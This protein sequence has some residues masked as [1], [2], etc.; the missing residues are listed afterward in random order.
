MKKITAYVWASGLIEFGDKVPDGALPV[1]SGE[2]KAVKDVIEVLA[3]HSRTA[4]VQLLVPGIPEAPNQRLA[5]EAL[6][7]FCRDV[8]FRLTRPRKAGIKRK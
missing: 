8:R 4:P 5:Q 2:E 1:I 7:K 3:R 6:I